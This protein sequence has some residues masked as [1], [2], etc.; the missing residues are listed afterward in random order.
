MTWEFIF[1]PVSKLYIYFGSGHV[2]KHV[3]TGCTTDACYAV[4]VPDVVTHNVTVPASDFIPTAYF[5]SLLHQY[6]CDGPLAQYESEILYAGALR[7]TLEGL[8]LTTMMTT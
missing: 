3:V 2:V 5:A 8:P 1:G 6:H 4:T 7:A